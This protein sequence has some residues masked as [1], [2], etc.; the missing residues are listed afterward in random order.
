MDNFYPFFLLSSGSKCL[1]INHI[2]LIWC[3]TM[4]VGNSSMSNLI[5][6]TEPEEN[7]K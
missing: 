6:K 7:I 4:Y 3:E 2:E 5:K 1:V